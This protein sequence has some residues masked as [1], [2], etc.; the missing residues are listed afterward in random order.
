MIFHFWFSSDTSKKRL[1]GLML[2]YK[3]TKKQNKYNSNQNKSLH[4]SYLLNN[5]AQGSYFSFNRLH[6]VQ[7]LVLSIEKVYKQCFRK[8]CK[9]EIW[10]AAVPASGY[11]KTNSWLLWCSNL[12]SA[13]A[14]QLCSTVSRQSVPLRPFSS[15]LCPVVDSCFGFKEKEEWKSVVH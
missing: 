1:L 2:V 9:H 6:F 3:N 11:E 15:R 10:Q 13:L 4:L 8:I 14:R 12:N 7:L 5:M